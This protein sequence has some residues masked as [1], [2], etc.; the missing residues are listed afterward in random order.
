MERKED[1]DPEWN[2]FEIPSEL[3]CDWYVIDDHD[4]PPSSPSEGANRNL[5]MADQNR[6]LDATENHHSSSPAS[7]VVEL[8]RFRSPAL[9]EAIHVQVVIHV[10]SC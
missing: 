10:L 5:S 8:P 4:R 3:D 9:W 6:N 2:P 1:N 7:F